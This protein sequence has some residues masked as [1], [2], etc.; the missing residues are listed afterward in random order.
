MAVGLARETTPNERHAS[1]QYTGAALDRTDCLAGLGFV[2]DVPRV[3]VIGTPHEFIFLRKVFLK[4]DRAVFGITP[5][6]NGQTG[7]G[8]SSVCGVAT[9]KAVPKTHNKTARVATAAEPGVH[10]LLV[11]VLNTRSGLITCP[12]RIVA[13]VCHVPPVRALPVESRNVAG[14]SDQPRIARSALVPGR[15]QPVS[16][17]TFMMV[18]GVWETA[19]KMST[20]GMPAAFSFDMVRGSVCLGDISR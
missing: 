19:V 5:I 7:V 12:L 15:R 16:G 13:T 18:A 10:G 6:A 3:P 17:S 9:L 8:W 4:G 20:S 2:S 14:S 1:R 11:P